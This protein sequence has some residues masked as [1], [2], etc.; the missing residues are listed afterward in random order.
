M[1][2]SA[3]AIMRSPHLLLALLVSAGAA[4][5]LPIA[6]FA[7]GEPGPAPL[8]RARAR[9]AL[10]SNGLRARR[11][12]RAST[13]SRCQRAPAR[14]MRRGPDS[15][16]EIDAQMYAEGGIRGRGVGDAGAVSGGKAFR[17]KQFEKRPFHVGIGYDGL[18]ANR[19]AIRER[20]PSSAAIFD[21]NAA[22]RRLRGA[23]FRR[24]ARSLPPERP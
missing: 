11:K 1:T 5:S 21:Q 12:D 9:S 4:P 15:G 20:H 24:A 18:C 16:H 14:D 17:L 13:S 8:R 7:L 3:A 10:V 2:V 6:R 19:P 22:D 23:P